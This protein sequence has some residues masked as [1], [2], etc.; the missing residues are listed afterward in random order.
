V[1]PLEPPASTLAQSVPP[2]ANKLLLELRI[3]DALD[4]AGLHRNGGNT[5]WWADG[6]VR[7]ERFERERTGFHAD[8]AALEL[9]LGSVAKARGA[10][11][12]DMA[13]RTAEETPDGWLVRC[14]DSAGREVRLRTPWLIDA[15]GRRGLVAREGRVPDRDTTTLALVRRWRRPGGFPDAD[16]MHTLV[17]SYRD[18]W[19]WS[20]P[21]DDEVRCFTAMVDQRHAGLAGAKL[22]SA[23]DAELDKTPHVGPMR[24][25]ATPL[26]AAWACSAAL[27]TSTRFGRPGLLLAGDAGS[28]I[29]P[30]SS[31]GVKKALSS[32][33]LAGI[34]VRTALTEPSMTSMA[35]TYFDEREHE[36]YRR[37]RARSASFFQ[38]C[39]DAYGHEYWTSRAEAARSAGRGATGGDDPDALVENDVSPDMARQAL[40]RIRGRPNFDAVRGSSV[41][42]VERPAV[43]GHRVALLPHLAS[44][45]A[46][47]G[48]RYV[49]NVDLARVVEVAPRH[50]EVPDGWSAYNAGAP[51]IS[52]PDYL[53]ALATAF[54]AGLLEHSESP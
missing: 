44:D 51:A 25:G 53:A 34:V 8:R 50:A 28:F 42:I 45:S 5:V 16:P 1:R 7:E 4:A 9:V 30:L 38:Q 31:F 13:A 17:E 26:D 10:E 15:T 3:R 23:L 29:D 6:S 27:Y 37:Y 49:R 33:W 11:V 54:A 20:V 19:A 40:E 41:R 39:A 18:G 14:S 52:L 22:D 2:S 48:L 47:S 24:Q 21:L 12:L 43:V 46:P 35:T 36:V 32:G